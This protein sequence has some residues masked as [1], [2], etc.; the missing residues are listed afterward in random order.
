MYRDK[1]SRSSKEGSRGRETHDLDVAMFANE[2][3]RVIITKTRT[4]AGT[5]N[6]YARTPQEMES[7]CKAQKGRSSFI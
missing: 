2:L 6:E 7:D 5:K 3:L 4:I 1:S